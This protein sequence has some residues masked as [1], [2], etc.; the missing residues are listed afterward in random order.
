MAF[1]SVCIRSQHV[2][3]VECREPSLPDSICRCRWLY[4]CRVLLPSG[5]Q[6]ARVESA[7][8]SM[9]RLH[10]SS[11][12]FVQHVRIHSSPS[13]LVLVLSFSPGSR[14]VSLR[15]GTSATRRQRLS[16]RRWTTIGDI[17][18][19]RDL[20]RHAVRGDRICRRPKSL[21]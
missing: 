18:F 20:Y 3:W 6:A 12:I 21:A 1:S 17:S 16:S 4:P 19:T 9:H 2:P 13:T 8:L 7:C 10:S 5:C 14:P 15:S 11:R